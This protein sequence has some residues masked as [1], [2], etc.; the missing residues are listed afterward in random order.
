M[1]TA[2]DACAS[3]DE[4]LI[5]RSVLNSSKLIAKLKTTN[6]VNNNSILMSDLKPDMMAVDLEQITRPAEVEVDKEFSVPSSPQGIKL[7]N[8][9][10]VLFFVCIHARVLGM[11]SR[12]C[13]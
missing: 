2:I 7:Q 11:G 8:S 10:Y 6:M 5:W 12:V 4:Y 13:L 1:P 9:A 3:I